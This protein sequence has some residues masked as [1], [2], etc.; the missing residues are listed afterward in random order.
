MNAV[1]C[2][3]DLICACQD[4]ARLKF[5]MFWG[6]K[7]KRKGVADKAVLSQWFPAAFEID[8]RI[9]PTAEHYM[10]AQKALLFGDFMMFEQIVSA[11]NPGKAKALGRQIAGF[12]EAVWCENRERIV[13]EGNVAKFG[14]HDDLKNFL[15]ETGDKVLVEASPWDRVW[16]I[17]LAADDPA[18]ARPA[19][20][21]GLNL[22]G[23]TL[24][25]VRAAWA[26]AA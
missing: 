4:G 16:G 3:D 10:M 21:P 6:H 19:E 14:Q 12:D 11:D 25:R 20:W 2:L 18:A 13:Y 17:G 15:L 7:P 1:Y 8:G 23:F 5:L 24:M 26:G 22:L 9:Y